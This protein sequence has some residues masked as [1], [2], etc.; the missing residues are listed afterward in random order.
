MKQINAG[1]NSGYISEEVIAKN[2]NKKCHI[3]KARQ[4]IWTIFSL[5]WMGIVS[6]IKFLRNYFVL[7]RVKMMLK[8]LGQKFFLMFL[9]NVDKK[10]HIYKGR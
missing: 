5:N 7:Y 9:L 10:C 3:Y 8:L 4:I 2:L 6:F 1:N